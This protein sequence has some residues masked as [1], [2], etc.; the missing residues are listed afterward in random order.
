MIKVS[1]ILQCSLIIQGQQC[2]LEQTAFNYQEF[3]GALKALRHLTHVICIHA[4][5][6]ILV[7]AELRM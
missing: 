1:G 4:Y 5:F 6:F 2:C 3:L 7:T